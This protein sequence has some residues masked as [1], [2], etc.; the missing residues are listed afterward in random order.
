MSRSVAGGCGAEPD[1]FCRR[2]AALHLFPGVCPVVPDLLDL[3]V[4]APRGEDDVAVL[5]PFVDRGLNAPAVFGVI[6]VPGLAVR[7]PQRRASD[8]GFAHACEWDAR[9]QGLLIASLLLLALLPQGLRL[10]G[11]DL[12]AEFLV[13]G[14]IV[15]D[16]EAA[17]KPDKGKVHARL[18][19]PCHN[20]SGRGWTS[21]REN[22]VGRGVFWT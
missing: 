10:P 11:G 6:V 12:D 14:G 9:A 15:G 19:T 20:D 2:R 8:V 21:Q 18:R 5:D 4:Q 22:A 3:S 1:F 7:L 16:V 17:A 13:T